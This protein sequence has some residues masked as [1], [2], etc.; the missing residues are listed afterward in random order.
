MLC[1]FSILMYGILDILS[2]SSPQS[3]HA[4]VW[5]ALCTSAL[6]ESALRA[7]EDQAEWEPEP[8]PLWIRTLCQSN[9][10]RGL[11]KLSPTP[12]PYNTTPWLVA[13]LPTIL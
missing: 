7:V 9:P 11:N 6:L 12:L 10:H 5:T 8:C 1:F 13:Y 4:S 3:V 2:I